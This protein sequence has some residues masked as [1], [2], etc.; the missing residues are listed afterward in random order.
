VIYVG[1]VT[2]IR[3]LVLVPVTTL[4][5]TGSTTDLPGSEVEVPVETVDRMM[6][7]D[8]DLGF[9]ATCGE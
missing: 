4:V 6:G 7:I 8:T 1:V 2:V 5:D 9:M 3:L